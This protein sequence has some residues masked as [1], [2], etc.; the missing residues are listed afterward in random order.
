MVKKFLEFNKI[1][2]IYKLL[3]VNVKEDWLNNVDGMYLVVS[4]FFQQALKYFFRHPL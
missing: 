4:W 2:V 1:R 3:A